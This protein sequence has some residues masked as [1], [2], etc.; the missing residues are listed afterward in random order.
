MFQNGFRPDVLEDLA[1]HV[2]SLLDD[3]G[4]GD[5]EDDAIQT[6]FDRVEKGKR[7]PRARFA[8]TSRN[9]E[10]EKAGRKFS[11]LQTGFVD[12]VASALEQ[13]GLFPGEFGLIGLE[14]SPHILQRRRSAAMGGE[15]WTE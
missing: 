9:G 1:V 7:E 2:G 3:A 14:L 8:P 10:A 11:G 4:I 5:G 15:V 6:V 12:S 13:R